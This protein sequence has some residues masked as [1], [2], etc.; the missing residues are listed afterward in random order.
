MTLKI[1]PFPSPD[2]IALSNIAS[3]PPLSLT[4]TWSRVASECQE[5][6]YTIIS[7]ECGD[8]PSSIE[9]TTV[10][11]VN[12]EVP[13]TGGREC[14]FGVRTDVCGNIDGTLDNILSVNLKCM[15]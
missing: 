5:V 9:S 7:S 8:C 1:E 4:F 11:C 2:S 15:L 13:S 3:G 10:V 12:V 14:T 6:L